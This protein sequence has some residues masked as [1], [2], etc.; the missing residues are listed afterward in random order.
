[1]RSTGFD[2]KSLEVFNRRL[3]KA[4]PLIVLVFAVLFLRLRFIQIVDGPKYRVQ[5]ENNRIHLR[6]IL[7][8]R[9]MVFD[10]RGE[11]LVDNRPSYDLYVLPEEI[12]GRKGIF[13]RLA[14][15][16]DLDPVMAEQKVRRLSRGHSFRPILIKANMTQVSKCAEGSR[17]IIGASF[18]EVPSVALADI[19][20]IRQ[21]IGRHGLDGILAI[22]SGGAYAL[23]AARA[24]IKKT[25][26]TA[27]EIAVESMKIAAEICVY[28]NDQI[29][30][31]EL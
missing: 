28:T 7:P 2:S 15:L 12:Q 5:S 1:M 19:R 16:I 14:G 20:R 17:G 6:D 11:L 3:N 4:T 23:A 31:K 27:K 30:V 13:R 22:G 21:D 9:W 18:R 8:F 26:M 29:I 25:D 24:L 10:R